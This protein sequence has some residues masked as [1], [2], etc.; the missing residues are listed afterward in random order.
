ML[1]AH[2][3]KD[4][5]PELIDEFFAGEEFKQSIAFM[6]ATFPRYGISLKDILAEGDKVVIR[7]TFRGTHK[8]ELMGLAPTGKDV[9]MPI[10]VTYRIANDK[11]VKGWVSADQLGLMQQLGVIT[12]GRPAPENYMWD[13]PS[14]VTG[15]PG[16]PEDNTAI[17]QVV[18]QI[19]LF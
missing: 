4:K 1:E 12:P 17:V 18:F 5:T 14:D 9:T 15:A 2:S 16:A 13:E 10:I 6:E 7:G 3:G 8:G 19:C 11:I